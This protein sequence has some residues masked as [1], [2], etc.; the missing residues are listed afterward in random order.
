MTL[1]FNIKQFMY[2]GFVITIITQTPHKVKIKVSIFN[3]CTI[4]FNNNNNNTQIQHTQ[5]NEI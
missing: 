1:I 4:Q 5:S 3:I 2:Y